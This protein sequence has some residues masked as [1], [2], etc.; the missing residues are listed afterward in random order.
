MSLPSRRT[1]YSLQFDHVA[2]RDLRQFTSASSGRFARERHVFERH[3]VTPAGHPPLARYVICERSLARP[4]STFEVI[5]DVLE[6]FEFENEKIQF[7][8]SNE[9]LLN[10]MCN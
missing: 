1:S 6:L 7:N 8:C 3:N 10:L 5:E 9:F 4:F 2:S